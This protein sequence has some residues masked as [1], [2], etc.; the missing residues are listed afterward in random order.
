[1]PLDTSGSVRKL[2]N[3]DAVFLSPRVVDEA[4]FEDFAGRLRREIGRADGQAAGL[5]GLIDEVRRA[6]QALEA[7]AK[8]HRS[9][10]EQSGSLRAEIEQQRA[11]VEALLDRAGGLSAAHEG[12]ERGVEEI[13]ARRQVE[14]AQL[15][16]AALETFRGSLAT[17]TDGALRAADRRAAEVES[18]IARMLSGAEDALDAKLKHAVS[19]AEH[20]IEQRV[21]RATEQLADV[22]AAKATLQQQ[23]DG[24]VAGALGALRNACEQAEGFV[25]CDQQTGSLGAR[26]H[27][28]EA[29]IGRLERLV[30]SSG[31]SEERI[32]SS[33]TGI[34][35][36]MDEASRRYI[37]LEESLRKAIRAS[38]AAEKQLDTRKDDV[39][40]LSQALDAARS[41]ADQS[42]QTLQRN[43]LHTENAAAAGKSKRAQLGDVVENAERLLAS[44]EPWRGVMLEHSATHKLPEEIEQVIQRV[45]QSVLS[46]YTRVGKGAEPVGEQVELKS[47]PATSQPPPNNR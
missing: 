3:S 44:F 19:D 34:N 26:L 1:M 13:L 12:F 45:R 32:T 28:A 20:R 17:I 14:I 9:Q 5:R 23:V 8:Q 36:Q 47:E 15:V 25:G 43:T 42:I 4:A 29:L 33:L 41:R 30:D 2:S 11:V 10:Q 22:S 18:K 37:S 40:Q 24:V 39:R 46:E 6:G 31:K 35:A 16:D 7:F 38:E 27:E 21:D